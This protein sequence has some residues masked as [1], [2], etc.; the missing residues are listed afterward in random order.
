MKRFLKPLCRGEK[1]FTLVELLVVIT[2]LGLLAAIAIP[3]VIEFIGRG[4]QETK[5]TDE[6]NIQTDV[7]RKMNVEADLDHYFLSGLLVSIL[8]SHIYLLFISKESHPIKTSWS[9]SS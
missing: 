4:D 8:G 7:Y 1:G 2:L 5:D 3:N 6:H 9:F